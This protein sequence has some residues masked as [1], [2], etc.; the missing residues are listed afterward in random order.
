MSILIVWKASAESRQFRAAGVFRRSIQ[1]QARFCLF[2]RD[3]RLVAIFGDGALQIAQVFQLF[4]PE[5]QIETVGISG[6]P[7]PR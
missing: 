3:E 2:P 1:F 5:I 6:Y 4:E 7:F